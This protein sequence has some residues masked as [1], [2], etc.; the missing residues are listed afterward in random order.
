MAKKNHVCIV[1]EYGWI[2]V[3]IVDKRKDDVIVM[4]D[5]AVVR[6]WLNGKGIG[7]IAQTENK[8][9]YTLDPIGKVEIRQS[10]V[11]FEIPCEW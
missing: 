11:L 6:K 4:S 10:K 2:I 3:G 1:C 8:D 9:D 7:A 5:G